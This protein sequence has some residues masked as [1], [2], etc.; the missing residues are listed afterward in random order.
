MTNLGTLALARGD[1]DLADER[2]TAAARVD[3]GYGYARYGQGLV[4]LQRHDREQA[5]RLLDEVLAFEPLTSPLAKQTI[6]LI[7][8]LE[9]APHE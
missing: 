9:E 7:Q 5:L 2:F 3:P 4:A 1:I 6:D 8:R